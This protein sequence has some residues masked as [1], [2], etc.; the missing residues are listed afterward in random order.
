[1]RIKNVVSVL[2]VITFVFA[3]SLAFAADDYN[4]GPGSCYDCPKC[5]MGEVPCPGTTP[6]P[7]GTTADNPTYPFDFDGMPHV[8]GG[9]GSYGYRMGYNF[10]EDNERNCKFIYDL[11]SCPEACQ[12]KAG[13]RMGIQM[14]I[15]TPGV[16]WAEDTEVHFEI[17]NNVNQPCVTNVDGIPSVTEMNTAAYYLNEA[18]ERVSGEGIADP[19]GYEVRS[20]GNIRYYRTFTEVEYNV[21]NKFVS[22]VSNE[23]TPLSGAYTGTIPSANRVV[24]LESDEQTD[25]VITKDDSHGDC[26]LWI[27]IPAMRIDPTVAKKGDIIEVQVRLLFSREVTGVCPECEPPDVCDCVLQVGIVC[28][29]EGV[30]PSGEYCMYFPYVLQGIQDAGWVSGIAVTGR[31]DLPDDAYCKLTLMDASGNKASYTNNSVVPIWTFILDSV[32]SNFSGDTLVP[33]ASSLEVIS[34]YR[35]DG[36]SFLDSG[37]FGAAT[38]PRS[39]TPGACCP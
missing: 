37:T 25:Y 39:C 20:F 36:Y 2:T 10:A 17:F 4:R 34:N 28:P 6:G 27:D 23:G 22:T 31:E 14:Y 35:I 8:E 16:Y 9:F 12:L 13:E 21:K 15:K 33:G 19:S 26:K 7:Q 38:L 24:A 11:C 5:P 32:M 1:M 18:E 3:F 29:G 30:T